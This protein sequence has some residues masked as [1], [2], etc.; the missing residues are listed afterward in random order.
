M[1]AVDFSGLPARLKDYSYKNSETLLTQTLIDG[2]SFLNY[3]NLLVDVTDR[4]DLTQMFI[5]EVLQPGGKD[6]FTPKG[7][8]GFKN[9]EG[10][11]RDCKVDF[12]L[13]PKLINAMWKSYLGRI[14]KSRRGDVYDAPFFQFILERIAAKVREELQ[15]KAAFQGVYRE[16][17]QLAAR[18]FD[19][20]LPLLSDAGAVPA[21]NIFAGAPITQNNAIDQLEG[22]VS[23][24]PSDKINEDLICLVEPTVMRHYNLDY[25]ATFGTIGTY[26]EFKKT[27]LDGTNIT[28]I[29]EP[30]LSGTNGVIITERENL[31]WLT[32]ELN[33]LDA[34]V[35]E[36]SKRNVN[37]ML[38]FQASADF[39]LGEMVWCND[40]ALT[41]GQALRTAAAAEPANNA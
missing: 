13:T 15:L 6:S 30:G 35:I 10:R 16:D 3:M 34:F 41:K 28:L 1:T 19:G 27:V 33:Q 40:L 24:V 32:G 18:V 31:T 36:K 14:N 29:A 4:V 38:D 20:I 2:M 9:R 5:S 22:L 8:V 17:S 26:T 39:A 23:L 25:R 7:T 12:L 37:V 11:V 21:G